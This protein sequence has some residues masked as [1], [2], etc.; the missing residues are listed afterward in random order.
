MDVVTIAFGIVGG[1]AIFLFGLYMLNDGLKKVVGEKLKQLL[2]KITNNRIKGC[3]FG[4]LTAATL[5][6]SGL[7][8]V[9]LMDLINQV[10]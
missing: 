4:A 3:V 8:M 1:L 10:F 2:T 5:Q 9:I 6:S 7:T